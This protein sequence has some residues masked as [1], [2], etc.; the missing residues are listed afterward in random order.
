M[1]AADNPY[2]ISPPNVLQSLMTGVQGYDRSHEMAQ[3]RQMEEAFKALGPQIQQGGLDNNA[4][5]TLFGLGPK[6]APMITAAAQFKKAM[7][8]NDAYYGVP[9]YSIDAQGNPQV[10]A[11][12]KKGEAKKLDF[13]QGSQVTPGVKVIDTPQGQ[14]VVDQKSGAL[15]GNP[16]RLGTPGQGWGP[17]PPSLPGV[18]S[19]P[20]PAG[21]PQPSMSYPGGLSP[22]DRPGFIPKNNRSEKAEQALG[23]QE[24]ENRAKLGA[25]TGAVESASSALDSMKATALQLG[26]HAGLPGITGLQGYLPN[27]R[28]GQAANADALLTNLKSQAGFA[29]LQAM[30][31]ASKTGGALGSVTEG[32]H[33]LLQNHL[34][35]LDKA[36]DIA[37]F[38]Q[39]LGKIIAF[40]NQS[41][42][43]IQKAYDQDYGRLK[44]G[45]A[46]Q[47][48][49]P[50]QAQPGGVVSYKDYFGAQ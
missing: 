26:A 19:A 39:E 5:G 40:T 48:L 44:S 35:A 49:Q 46:G 21:Q 29:V 28:G 33:T 25:A 3:Q 7:G 11:Y 18:P 38:K 4:L 22:G 23:T 34:A 15:V 1:A 10:S 2:F 42:A 45:G 6:A 50:V 47:S 41:K 30:R 17:Q 12:N 9:I 27:I 16:S 14:Y 32:E 13:G 24:G 37:Q 20:G 36:Q 31:E 8:E 43:R